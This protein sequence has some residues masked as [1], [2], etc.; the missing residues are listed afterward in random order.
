MIEFSCLLY[1]LSSPERRGV[2][3]RRNLATLLEFLD[4]L[5]HR[6]LHL[7]PI[8]ANDSACDRVH[9]CF[10][11]SWLRRNRFVLLLV[12]SQLKARLHPI[13]FFGNW[14]FCLLISCIVFFSK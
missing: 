14:C 8:L 5:D 2:S 9:P 12:T 1:I 13:W 7:L 11:L 4:H 6:H 3:S 10:R